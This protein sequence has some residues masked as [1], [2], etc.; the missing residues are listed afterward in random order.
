MAKNQEKKPKNMGFFFFFLAKID[1]NA[2]NY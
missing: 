1:K 2:Q